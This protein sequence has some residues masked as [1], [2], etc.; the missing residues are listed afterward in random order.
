MDFGGVDVIANT[1][2]ALRI[3]G[4]RELTDLVR[5]V[6]NH[7]VDLHRAAGVRLVVGARQIGFL[8][9][10]VV[11]LAVGGAGLETTSGAGETAA[12]EL[13]VVGGAGV[14]LL[15]DRLDTFGGG[16]VDETRRGGGARLDVRILQDFQRLELVGGDFAESLTLAI[17]VGTQAAL[18]IEHDLT[19]LI[20]GDRGDGTGASLAV[21]L[22][23][24]WLIGLRVSR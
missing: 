24:D 13:G 7:A 14:F 19:G 6:H 5:R 10:G 16:V 4:L 3:G 17:I 18:Q 20:C 9:L 15:T 23:F 2:S 1:L 11:G 12:A 8:A 22:L 21:G